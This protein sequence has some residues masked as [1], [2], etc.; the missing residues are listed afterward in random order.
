MY[1][2]GQVET[3]GPAQPCV[4]VPLTVSHCTIAVISAPI[5]GKDNKYRCQRIYRCIQYHNLHNILQHMNH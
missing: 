4:T 2:Q 1:V 5:D 3:F